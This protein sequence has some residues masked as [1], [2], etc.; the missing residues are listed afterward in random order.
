MNPTARYLGNKINEVKNDPLHVR[1]RG[2][3]KLNI[4]F[5]WDRAQLQRLHDI[6]TDHGISFSELYRVIL[7]DFLEKYRKSLIIRKKLLNSEK[8]L[9]SVDVESA[10]HGGSSGCDKNKEGVR[11]SDSELLDKD[12]KLEG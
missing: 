12:K 5:Y 3:E 7:D 8:S 11:L 1:I 2:Y 6:A 9:E 10:H 4:C